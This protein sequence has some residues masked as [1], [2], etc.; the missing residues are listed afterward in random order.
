MWL[1]GLGFGLRPDPLEEHV[2]VRF[3]RLPRIDPPSGHQV[4]IVV[5]QATLTREAEVSEGGGI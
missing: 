5:A 4:H 1:G 3:G 2:P